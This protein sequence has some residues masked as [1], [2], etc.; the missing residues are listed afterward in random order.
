MKN[1]SD[2]TVI[3][4]EEGRQILAR[5]RA[6]GLRVCVFVL[7]ISVFSNLK[8][9]SVLIAWAVLSMVFM[10]LDTTMIAKEALSIE[11]VTTWGKS[12]IAF[13]AIVPWSFSVY[14]FFYRGLW[15]LVGLFNGFSWS[16]TGEAFFFLVMGYL[17]IRV[18]YPLSEFGQQVTE[19]TLRFKE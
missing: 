17:L 5:F 13:G 16:V 18:L 12:I 14:L 11:L 15:R 2:V 10:W 4:T 1:S 19:K 3:T 9:S 7:L 8:D 6:K